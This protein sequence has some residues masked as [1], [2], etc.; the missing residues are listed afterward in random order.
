MLVGTG[1]VLTLP[2]ANRAGH[3]QSIDPAV[4]GP[5]AIQSPMRPEGSGDPGESGDD[6]DPHVGRILLGSALGAVGGAGLGAALLQGAEAARE[7]HDGRYDDPNRTDPTIGLSMIG[8]AFI[9]GGA[10]FGAVRMGGIERGRRG[11]Y[12]VGGIGEFVGGGV[13]YTLANQVHES[14]TARYVGLGVGWVLGA[15]GG[16]LLAASQQEQSTGLVG[17]SN[18]EWQVSRPVV[19]PGLTFDR[20]SVGVTLVSVRF[21]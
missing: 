7:E 12:V 8:V 16:A 18:G 5:P 3:A 21:Q 1:L 19:R 11:A 13:G 17:Y 2:G 20:P 10:P 14:R 4:S 9:V 6:H 15:A